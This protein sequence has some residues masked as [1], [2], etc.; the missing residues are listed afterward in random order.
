MVMMYKTLFAKLGNCPNIP[1]Q[2]QVK[3]NRN[4]IPETVYG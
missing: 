1:I 3:G 4:S 2:Q